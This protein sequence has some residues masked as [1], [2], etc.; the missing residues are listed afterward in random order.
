MKKNIYLCFIVFLL[1][2]CKVNMLFVQNDRTLIHPEEKY[3][4]YSLAQI[5]FVYYPLDTLLYFSKWKI[6]DNEKSKKMLAYSCVDNRFYTITNLWE[7]GK[8]KEI[9]KFDKFK[10]LISVSRYCENGFKVFENKKNEMFSDT[11]YYCNGKL[12]QVYNKFTGNIIFFESN[13]DTSAIGNYSNNYTKNSLWI[14][15]NPEGKDKIYE[16]Y[17]EG[18]MIFRGDSI[19]EWY[20]R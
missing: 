9:L 14:Y 1:W 5:G 20:I 6:F 7:N 4:D 13:G 10:N 19:P 11:L 17:K 3:E 12:Q 8:I 18:T 15:N 2:S 16:I